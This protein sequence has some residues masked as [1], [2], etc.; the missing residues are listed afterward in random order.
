MTTLWPR[1][2]AQLKSAGCLGEKR[3]AKMSVHKAYQI[4]YIINLFEEQALLIFG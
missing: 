1:V 3:P 2:Y 4:V